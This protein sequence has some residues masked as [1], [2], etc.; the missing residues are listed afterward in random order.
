M[1]ALHNYITVDTTTFLSNPKN[2]EAIYN[3]C[4]KVSAQIILKFPPFRVERH[5][6]TPC[7]CVCRAYPGSVFFVAITVA[8]WEKLVPNDINLRQGFSQKVVSTS[9]FVFNSL[10]ARVDFFVC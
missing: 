5:F 10:A 4:K 1:P 2:I 7:V 6:F 8:K 9:C 3:M